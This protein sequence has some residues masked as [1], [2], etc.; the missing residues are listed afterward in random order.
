MIK[1]AEEWLQPKT[2]MPLYS[3]AKIVTKNGTAF[4]I[5][6]DGANMQVDPYSSIRAIDQIAPAATSS[7]DQT[8]IRRLRIMLGRAKYEEQPNRERNT[9]IELPTAVAALRGTGGWFG[10][11][12]T[13][14]SQG[15]LYE[16]NMEVTGVFQEIIPRILDLASALNSPT[17]SASLN[18]AAQA[19]NP[20]ANVREIQAEIQTFGTNED[21]EIQ[22]QVQ[23]TLAVIVPVI[24]QIQQKLEKA[25]TAETQK[26]KADQA[27]AAATS[28][29]PPQVTEA[30]KMASES[31]KT[32]MDTTRESTKADIS[33]VL[34]TL[35][36]N[37]QGIDIAQAAKQRNDRAM[38]V[39]EQAV[40]TAV[41][42]AALASTAT[43]EKQLDTA[44]AVARTAAATTQTIAETIKTSNIT[45]RLVAQNNQE[46]LARST[47]LDDIAEKTLTAAEKSGQSAQNAIILAQKEE[48][49]D[50]ALET[51]RT[52]EASSR[53][54]QQT[55]QRSSQAAQAISDNDPAADQLIEENQKETDSVD[56]I[57]QSLDETIETTQPLIPETE[58]D[59]EETD[60]EE[61]DTEETDTDTEETQPE[62]IESDEP[63]NP[64]ERDFVDDEEPASPV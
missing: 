20:L 58:D 41:Q 30:N 47:A 38:T 19:D 10:A 64:Q 7:S 51:A 28:D 32:F 15:S 42:A 18:S 49:L 56:Q 11:D 34:E 22:K 33:L 37:P 23:Q 5:F 16:G 44:V 25:R 12:E 35:K 53:A 21:P 4:V 2:D 62:V 3:G 8:K 36:A 39:A 6:K 45:N 52:G 57:I 48:T 14:N 31:N 1:N 13:L 60:T 46:G 29:T 61:T 59:T 43:S 24:S 17:W 63:E 40:T 9:R 50:I 26:S 55:A 27:V 54:I